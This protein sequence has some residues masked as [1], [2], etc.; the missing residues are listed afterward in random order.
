M[1]HLCHISQTVPG[2]WEREDLTSVHSIGTS[3]VSPI[4]GPETSKSRREAPR[5]WRSIRFPERLM[6]HP[7]T[8]PVMWTSPHPSTAADPRYGNLLARNL[9]KGGLHT[10]SYAWE[11]ST[12]FS[13]CW[14][15]LSRE[16]DLQVKIQ[17]GLCLCEGKSSVL[18][19]FLQMFQTLAHLAWLPWALLPPLLGW[20]HTKL[21]QE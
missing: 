5:R 15:L 7:R 18:P 8:A 21:K 16:E 13:S 6:S 12:L 11:N 3:A 20:C 19:F 4:L 10:S 1:S 17:S 9:G 14:Q 2:S